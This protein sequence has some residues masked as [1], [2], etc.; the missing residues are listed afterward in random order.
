M[1]QKIVT[2]FQRQERLPRTLLEMEDFPTLPPTRRSST[3]FVCLSLS[4]F[5]E[6]TSNILLVFSGR[7]ILL[8]LS[9]PL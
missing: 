4:N 3:S 7:G 6:F 2:C 1:P 5:E 9:C 8:P